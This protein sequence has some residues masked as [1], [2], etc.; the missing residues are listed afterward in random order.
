MPAKNR[1]APPQWTVEEPKYDPETLVRGTGP[2]GFRLTVRDLAFMEVLLERNYLARRHIA[3]LGTREGVG[4]GLGETWFPTWARA[5]HR[6]LELCHMGLLARTRVTS[7]N[8]ETPIGA[9]M[10]YSLT[11][12]G[13]K[14]LC[15]AQ[16]Q[17]AL[18]LERTWREP[19]RLASPRIN[20]AHDLAALDFADAVM[21]ALASGCGITFVSSRYLVQRVGASRIHRA[22]KRDT[23]DPDAAVIVDL[24]KRSEVLLLEY[25][26]S[27][28]PNKL[29]EKI[30]A[31]RSYFEARSWRARFPSQPR[32]ILSVSGGSD[33]QRYWKNALG[34]TLSV[35]ETFGAAL[36]TVKDQLWVVAEEDWR[37]GQLSWSTSHAEVRPLTALCAEDGVHPQFGFDHLLRDPLTVR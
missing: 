35:A 23:I 32:V 25:E 30:T 4:D 12:H 5:N 16:Y 1:Y 2:G 34:S 15:V 7:W 24:D 10:A 18:D 17:T 9:E 8:H 11:R 26:E 14:C 13:F 33:R 20:L 6:L 22:P 28:R 36:W 21:D 3:R 31:Y 37:M 29:S 19:W 27:I